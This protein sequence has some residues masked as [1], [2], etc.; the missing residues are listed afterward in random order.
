MVE[1]LVGASGECTEMMIDFAYK[2]NYAVEFFLFFAFS[3]D[4]HP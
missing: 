2:E 3:R 4:I 1:L